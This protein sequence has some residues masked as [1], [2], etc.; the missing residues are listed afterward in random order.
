MLLQLLGTLD[1]NT[2]IAY[3]DL[4]DNQIDDHLMDEIDAITSSRQSRSVPVPMDAEDMSL[5]IQRIKSDDPNL[6][7]V[8]LDGINLVNSSETEDL[9]DALA[10]NTCVTKLSLNNTGID[11]T[12][13]ATL[14]LALVDNGAIT[15]LSMRSNQIGSEG[16]E[17]VSARVLC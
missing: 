6:I 4:S 2:T 12:L 10:S 17:Y 15:H 8:K 14:S 3:I 5:L 11:D 1:S 13:M 7:E 9:I 16:C